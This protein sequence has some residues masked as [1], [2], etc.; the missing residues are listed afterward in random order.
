MGY[1]CCGC[2]TGVGWIVV[3]QPWIP[4]LEHEPEGA[5]EGTG[6]GLQQQVSTIAQLSEKGQRRGPSHPGLGASR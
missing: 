3:R 5:V 4:L 6:S 1:S 2:L